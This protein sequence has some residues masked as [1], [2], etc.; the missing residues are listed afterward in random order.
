MTMLDKFIA[1]ASGLPAD[2]R[3]SV[4]EALAAL[5]ES[6][7][8]AYDLTSDELAEIDRRVAKPSLRF[9]SP[10]AIAKLFGKPFSA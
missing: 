5:M 4:E 6:M 1:F 3:E 9:A 8:G 7:S 2:Q 10:E